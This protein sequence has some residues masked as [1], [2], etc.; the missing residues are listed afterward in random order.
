M[1]GPPPSTL[2]PQ[3]QLNFAAGATPDVARDLIDPRAV[4]SIENGLLDDDGLIYGRGG[5]QA[6]SSAP[7]DSSGRFVW[8]GVLTPGERTV[9]GSRDS[10]GVLAA[11]GHTILK[12]GPGGVDVPTPGRAVQGMLF[13]PDGQ[14]YGGSRKTAAYAAGTVTT[15]NGSAIVTGA[16]TAFT[17]NV[18]VGMLFRTGTSER[19]Y[20]VKSVDGDG[21]ITLRDPYE[22]STAGGKTYTLKPLESATTPYKWGKL[23]AAVGNRL[24]VV[25]ADDTVTFSERDK[26]HSF[27]ANDYHRVDEGVKIRAIEGAAAQSALVFTN[28]G[29]YVIRNMA[30][31][32]VDAFGNAQQRIDHADGQLR[33]LG[34]CAP[35]G[36]GVVVMGTDGVYL[37]DGISAPVQIAWGSTRFVTGLVDSGYQPGLATVF[38]GHYCLPVLSSSGSWITT[39]VWRLDRPIRHRG[40]PWTYPWSEASGAGGACTAFASSAGAAKLL[41]AA[42]TDGS[43][44]DCTHWFD[45]SAANAL[46]FDGSVPY[47]EIVTRDFPLGS[48]SLGRLRRAT[49]FYE[50]LTVAGGDDPRIHIDAGSSQSRA[51]APRWGQVKWNEFKWGAGSQGFVE[52]GDGDGAPAVGG[53]DAHGFPASYRARWIRLRIRCSDRRAKVTLRGFE[54]RSAPA[55]PRHT[56][57]KAAV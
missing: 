37:V 1:A 13:L 31:N 21:Q 40:Y 43:L 34:G 23:M 57:V 20:V 48:N 16:G 27:L 24:L 53:D 17:A 33:G 36:G 14:I 55:S 38:R 45:P 26:P 30:L 49:L 46:D 11:D 50:L 32:I 22:G 4:Y 47:W 54:I 35:Y 41:G 9:F 52:I 8:N 39:L 3:A 56:R 15:T 19:A 29:L 12:L 28:N 42:N 44:I 10:W 18:D 5:A 25:T 2:L 51:G 7:L 6:I